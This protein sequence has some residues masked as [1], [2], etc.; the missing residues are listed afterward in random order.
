M[1]LRFLAF[2]DNGDRTHEPDHVGEAVFYSGASER[3][4]GIGCD[5]VKVG[6]ARKQ[7]GIVGH[8]VDGREEAREVARVTKNAE[9]V[10]ALTR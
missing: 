7:R 5:G 2:V 9:Y 3:V 8:S 4:I 1:T 6:D 10:F